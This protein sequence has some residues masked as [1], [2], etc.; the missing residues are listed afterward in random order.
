MHMPFDDGSLDGA[1]AIEATCHSPDPVGCYTEIGRVLKPGALFGLYEWCLTSNYD[2]E[3]AEHKKVKF[4]IELGSG[5]PDII[6]TEKCLKSVEEAGFEIVEYID[7]AQNETIPWYQTLNASF[8]LDGIKHTKL[9]RM[10]TANMVWALEKARIVPTGATKIHDS[11]LLGAD[12]LVA[13][14]QKQIFTPMFFVLARK[15]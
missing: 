1:Y 5:L 9:G 6:T 2:G 14:G 10:V 7:L 3:N 13:G 8:S 12:A 4:E 11:M 15:K